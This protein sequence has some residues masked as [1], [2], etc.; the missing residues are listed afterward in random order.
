MTD[1]QE[2]YIAS[3]ASLL[4]DKCYAIS[5]GTCPEDIQMP[6]RQFDGTVKKQPLSRLDVYVLRFDL[7]VYY[8]AHPNIKGIDAVG[9][10]AWR[11]V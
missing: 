7:D 8:R 9:P 4:Q 6:V 2:L 10:Y 11:D 5:D 1:G 3:D